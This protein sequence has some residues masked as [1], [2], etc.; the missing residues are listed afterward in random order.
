VRPPRRGKLHRLDD[1]GL[2]GVVGRHE[3]FMG[4]H[5]FVVRAGILKPP[6]LRQVQAG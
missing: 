4:R 2:L 3:V 6:V 5:Y 1:T